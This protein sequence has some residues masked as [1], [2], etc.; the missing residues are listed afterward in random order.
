MGSAATR[1]KRKWNNLHYTNVTVALNPDIVV[2]LKS[3][4]SEKGV[5]VN[6]VITG[7]VAEYL[8]VESS[9]SKAVHSKKTPDS[10]ARRKKELLKHIA[11]IEGICDREET[12]LNNIP[13]NLRTSIRY[14]NAENCIEHLLSA[15]DELK[16]A[17][18]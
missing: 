8:C 15:I 3:T 16:D 11:A 4:C 17:Y 10:R 18:S 13:E 9:H 14:E 6:S 2:K 1:A 5:S 7:L 12:Y